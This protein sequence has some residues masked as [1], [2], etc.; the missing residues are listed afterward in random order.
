MHKIRLSGKCTRDSTVDGPGL[1]IVI[2]TQGCLHNCKGC[3]N[4]HTH[5]LNGGFTE[6]IDKVI[7]FINQSKIQRGITLSGGEPFLQPEALIPIV[8]AAIE[9]GLNVWAFSGYTYEQ[10]L[11][12]ENKKALLD[13]VD[14]LVDGPFILEQKDERLTYKGSKNQRII[15]VKQ[16]YAQNKVVLSRYDEVNADF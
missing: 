2:W 4:P 6:D 8:K 3:H 12:D 1:R 14:V 5:D 9:K 11:K 13:Y 10:L 16:S 15:D 7:E